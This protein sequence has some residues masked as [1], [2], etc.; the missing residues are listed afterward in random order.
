MPVAKGT[1]CEPKFTPEI[2]DKILGYLALGM[3]MKDAADAAGVGY[4]TLKTW[5]KDGRDHPAGEHGEFEQDARTARATGKAR[6]LA[7]I[8]RA[9]KI[10]WAASAWRLEH[11]YAKEFRRTERHEVTGADGGPMQ[12]IARVALLP[13]LDTPDEFIANP[14][15]SAGSRVESQPRTPDKIP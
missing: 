5:R 13:A 15:D 7:N 4:R 1:P 11:I 12:T 3:S 6:D 14:N 8:S 9:G 10:H 2:K